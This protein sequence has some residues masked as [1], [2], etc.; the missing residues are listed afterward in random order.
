MGKRLQLDLF[1]AAAAAATAD[2]LLDLAVRLPDKCKCGSAVA[3]IGAGKGPH[4]AELCCRDCNAHRGWLSRET[5][6]FL[7]E[8]VN[9]FGCP[10]APIM[11]RRGNC[12]INSGAQL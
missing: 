10:D 11:I 6:G 5:H 7:T 12:T 4:Q 3:L 2:P 1:T 8:I 9:K